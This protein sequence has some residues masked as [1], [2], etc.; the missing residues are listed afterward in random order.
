MARYTG[1]VCKLC[2]H[3]GDKLFLK[4]TRCQTD[5]CAVARRP[6]GPGQH[7]K[8]HKKESD[9]GLQVKEKQ[10]VKRIY[11]VLERQFRHYFAM[12][13]KSKGVTGT[14]LLQ[15]L[16]R[17]MDNTIFKSG[18]ALSRAQARL[19][20][21]HRLFQINGRPVNIPSRLV[22]IGDKI[23]LKPKDNYKT[24]INGILEY[25]KD[26]AVPAWLKVDKANLTVEVVAMP[27]REDTGFPVN[28]NMIV[29]LY[30]K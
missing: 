7:G 14:I 5:K 8:A 25:S 21:R 6:F 28:E 23:S 2:R 29:E 30:S 27:T 13:T 15:L 18:F 26:R 10:K 11:G 3:H 20:A 16:E 22:R 1:S 24:K 4:G 19:M 17:R 9:Y 12:A